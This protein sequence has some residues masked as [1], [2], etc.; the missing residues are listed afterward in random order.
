MANCPHTNSIGGITNTQ[1]YNQ[2]SKLT[3][4][5]L[6]AK[7]V[8]KFKIDF[9]LPDKSLINITQPLIPQRHNPDLFVF[10]LETT[11]TDFADYINIP[12]IHTFYKDIPGGSCEYDEQTNTLLSL[13]SGYRRR[14]E[15]RQCP[16]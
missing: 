12:D 13:V 7:E 16:G 6:R 10:I 14:M 1:Y 11:L 3:N 9:N 5:Q 8:N 15:A 2:I 4:T